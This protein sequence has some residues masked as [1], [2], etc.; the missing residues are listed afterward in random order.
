[1]VADTH[2]ASL[3]AAA[4][5]AVVQIHRTWLPVSY[6]GSSS[7]E[8]DDSDSDEEGAPLTTGEIR[9]SV[10]ILPE[11]STEDIEL[12]VEAD[13]DGEDDLDEDSALGVEVQRRGITVECCQYEVDRS[14]ECVPGARLLCSASSP[15]P[16]YAPACRL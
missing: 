8:D 3:L 5:A 10:H 6:C 16:L 12:P 1:V 13:I 7:D 14:F 11:V 9:I 2:S 15:P 4:A